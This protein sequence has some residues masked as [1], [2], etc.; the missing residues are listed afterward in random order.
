VAVEQPG[1][2]REAAQ[3][4]DGPL[5]R[6]AVGDDG[7]DTPV[8][9]HDRAAADGRGAGA[10]DQRGATEDGARGQMRPLR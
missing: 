10:V 9:D 2:E 4:D 7:R 6:V 1:Q 5:A 3:V 8:L